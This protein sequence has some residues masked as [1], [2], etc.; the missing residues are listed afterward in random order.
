M[1][2]RQINANQQQILMIIINQKRKDLI[3]VMKIT[4][5]W[6]AMMIIMLK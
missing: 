4:R 2:H 3:Q 1:N 6:I 5:M